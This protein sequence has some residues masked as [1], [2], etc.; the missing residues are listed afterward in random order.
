MLAHACSHINVQAIPVTGV[1][2][3]VSVTCSVR[4]NYVVLR[5]ALDSNSLNIVEIE[6][7]GNSCAPQHE[8][9]STLDPH[10]ELAFC[11]VDVEVMTDGVTGRTLAAAGNYCAAQCQTRFTAKPNH[12]ATAHAHVHGLLL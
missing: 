7:Y 2:A 9:T 4:G 5:K 10:V 3:E 12:P 6:A 11:A 8:R 1:C